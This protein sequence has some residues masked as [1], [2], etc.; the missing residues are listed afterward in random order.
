MMFKSTRQRAYRVLPATG[1]ARQ[2]AAKGATISR[3]DPATL[4]F[5]LCMS[6]LQED[7]QFG[8]KGIHLIKALP[9]TAKQRLRLNSTPRLSAGRQPGK[10]SH[11]EVMVLQFFK[12]FRSSVYQAQDSFVTRP[13]GKVGMVKRPTSGGAKMAG[14]DCETMVNTVCHPFND[15]F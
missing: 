11:I 5:E 13:L 2:V 14:K 12:G 8:P 3:T 7:R 9:A 1:A 10:A 15:S 6:L 4:A